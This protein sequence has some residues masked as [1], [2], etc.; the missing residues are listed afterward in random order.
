MEAVMKK[1][2]SDAGRLHAFATGASLGW[3]GGAV[4]WQPARRRLGSGSARRGGC[5]EDRL[6]EQAWHVWMGECTR[7]HLRQPAWVY[8]RLR[9]EGAA[10]IIK[11]T[12]D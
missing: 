10:I 7:Q 11:A 2:A 5:S 1:D 6:V 9:A 12:S 3:C 8:T 4:S